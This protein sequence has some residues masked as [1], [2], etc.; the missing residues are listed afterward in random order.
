VFD[1]TIA[2]MFTYTRI[3]YGVY[4]LREGKCA[5]YE[6]KACK[7]KHFTSINNHSVHTI[8]KDLKHLIIRT[9]WY[10]IG[11]LIV[12][13]LSRWR[14][15]HIAFP[16][17]SRRLSIKQN[18]KYDQ[19]CSVGKKQGDAEHRKINCYVTKAAIITNRNLHK[20]TFAN[21]QVAE[22]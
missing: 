11:N 19:C 14:W 22:F 10:F 1:F 9:D 13:D 7:Y 17:L 8:Q 15:R 4:I 6:L 2:G 18:W 20:N 3:T 12:I 5:P 21:E 16:N